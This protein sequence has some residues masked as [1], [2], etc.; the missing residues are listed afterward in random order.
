MP[1]FLADIVK[2][3]R[4]LSQVLAQKDPRPSTPPFGSRAVVA[5]TTAPRTLFRRN[6]FSVCR[7][8][9]GESQFPSQL[10]YGWLTRGTM[11]H[12]RRRKQSNDH[13]GEGLRPNPRSRRR[14]VVVHLCVPGVYL[15]V[16]L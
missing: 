7:C 14:K 13:F 9:S 5:R 6:A 2:D 4:S 11:L 3:S 12:S 15:S 8:R 16:F 1:N 10:C